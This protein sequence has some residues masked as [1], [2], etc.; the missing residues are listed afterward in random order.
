MTPKRA[1][2]T[3][4][5]WCFDKTLL[6]MCLGAGGT[7][8][9]IGRVLGGACRFRVT[10]G[11]ADDARTCCGTCRRPRRERG[12]GRV[13]QGR[14]QASAHWLNDTHTR[15]PSRR[16]YD[17]RARGASLRLIVAIFKRARCTPPTLVW[18]PFESGVA[19]IA[20]DD[21][22]PFIVLTC[23]SLGGHLLQGYGNYL[24]DRWY[25][26]EWNITTL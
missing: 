21:C 26:W 14:R 24:S 1:N 15:S 12:G 23:A 20:V 7:W 3:S 22:T 10:R 17:A 2:S 11:T 6:S 9:A 19:M 4:A 16:R 18:I 8:I 25:A 5:I 13:R